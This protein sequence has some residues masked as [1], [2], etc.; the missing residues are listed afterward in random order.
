MGQPD[1]LTKTSVTPER[2]VEKS[3]PRWKINRHAEG[4]KWAID[5][6]WGRMAKIGFFGQKPNG[7]VVAPGI[8]VICPIDKN[9]NN[10]T[11]N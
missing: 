8:L 6:N 9:R 5:Q 3:I 7:K 2:K 10:Y 4:Y 1:F 11:K